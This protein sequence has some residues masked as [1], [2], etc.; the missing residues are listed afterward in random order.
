[1]SKAL[2]VA[3]R[4]FKSRG[5]LY[6][7]GQ[8]I[9][10]PSSI[11]LL[12][13]RILDRD[14]LELFEGDKRNAAWLDYLKVRAKKPLDPRI[15]LIC[16]GKVDEPTPAAPVAPTAPAAPQKPATPI[17]ATPATA[18]NKPVAAKPVAAVKPAAPVKPTQ[19]A[20]KPTV[21]K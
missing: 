15:I 2:Y 10:N 3:R 13:S 16:G 12:R 8:V 19:A 4:N 18:A 21:N 5:V 7:V 9:E 20:V 11:T 1:M 17:A 14:V 6:E